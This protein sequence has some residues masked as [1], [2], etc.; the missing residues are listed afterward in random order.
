LLEIGSGQS[1]TSKGERGRDHLIDTASAKI[2]IRETKAEY[3]IEGTWGAKVVD[4]LSP[5]AAD[6]VI[7][8]RGHS[9]FGTTHLHRLLRNLGVESVVVAGGS[10]TGC[11]AD[12]VREGVGLGYRISIVADATYPP[13]KRDA[14]FASLRERLEIRTTDETVAVHG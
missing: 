7:R 3:H 11:V 1:S 14:A 8:K 9:A 13:G 6:Y 4:E 5:S 10:V 2:A 12:T